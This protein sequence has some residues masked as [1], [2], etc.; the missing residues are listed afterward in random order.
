LKQGIVCVC[1]F[2]YVYGYFICTP[3]LYTALRGQKESDTLVNGVVA[4]TVTS[5]HVVL[6][7]ELLSSGSTLTH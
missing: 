1:A 2:L 3:Y 7:F 4:L 6:G 5:Y